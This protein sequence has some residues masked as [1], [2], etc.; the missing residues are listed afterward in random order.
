MHICP[1]CVT[2]L[3]NFEVTQGY[4]DVTDISVVVKFRIKN[5]ELR[6]KNVL[7]DVPTDML[8]WTTTPWTLPGNTLLAVSPRVEYSIVKTTAGQFILAA[9]R[10][11]EVISPDDIL[12]RRDVPA[13]EL[14]GLTYEP[15]FPYFATTEHAFRVVAAD[16]VTTDDGTGVVHIAPAFG[17]DDFRVGEAE[18]VPLVQH[19]TMEGKFTDRVTDFAGLDVKPKDNPSK[20]DIEII[21]WLAHHDQLFSKKKFTHSYPHCW[22]CDSPLLNYATSSWFVKVTAIQQALIDNNEKITWDPEH[23]KHGRFGKWLEGVKDWSISR[24]RFWGT[25]LPVWVCN[26][27]NEELRMKNEECGETVVVGSIAELEKLSGVAVTDLHKHIIDPITFPCAK[28]GGVMQ[29][30][31]EVFDTWF[32]SGAVPYGQDHYPFENKA[33]F[34]ARFPADYIAESQDQT[35][36]WFYTLHVLATAL[37]LPPT[38]SIPTEG[39]TSAF[40][41]VSVNGIILAEDGQK[42]E[43]ASQ[44]LS[45]SDD[46]RRKIWC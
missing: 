10:L 12:S 32:D 29:R 17:E 15:L 42:N 11:H 6:M 43:Q 45:R 4:K 27:A 21:K 24:N 9:S 13:S 1:S 25:P 31:P 19:V 38:A 22:R 5:D 3:S 34:E 41:T 7:G 39:S 36:G 23:M 8:A 37:T 14:V 26:S 16:F 35:R 2:P 28:C 20:A 46:G 30:V 44:E 40:K 33:R 18:G